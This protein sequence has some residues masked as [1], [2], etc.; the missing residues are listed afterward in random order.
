MN[1]SKATVELSKRMSVDV[2]DSTPTEI[3]YVGRRAQRN[4]EHENYWKCGKRCIMDKRLLVYLVQVSFSFAVLMFA[5]YQISVTSENQDATI[6]ISIVSLIV[7]NFM[8]SVVHL[9]SKEL[10]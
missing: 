7:G 3:S 4:F 1:K 10:K 5:F 8:P 6:W 9:P 2:S